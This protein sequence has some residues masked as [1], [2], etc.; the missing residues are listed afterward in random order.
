MFSPGD[1]GRTLKPFVFL[2]FLNGNVSKEGLTFGMHP[3]SGQQTLTYSNAPVHYTDTEGR[4]GVLPPGGLEYMNPGGG[5][6]HD[7]SFKGAIEGLRAFQF[8]FASPPG[9]ED[10]PSESIFLDPKDL[11]RGRGFKLLMGIYDGLENPLPNHSNVNVLDIFLEKAGDHFKY[12]YPADH[13]TSFVFVYEGAGLVADDE[14]ESSP[15][16]VFVIDSHG[17]C[18]EVISTKPNTRVIIGSAVPMKH[19]LSLGMYSVHTSPESLAKGEARIN[20]LGEKLF[21]EGKLG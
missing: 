8:W 12:T 6:W 1:L 2:D 7:S 17:D 18:L 10:G 15:T 16:E 21:R 19:S 9:I 20:E 3:H 5:A 13:A 14:R 4:K 11:P